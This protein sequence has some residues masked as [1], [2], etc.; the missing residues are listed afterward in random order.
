MR[1]WFDYKDVNYKTLNQLATKRLI[2]VNKILS[3]GRVIITDRLHASIMSV[4][5][6]KP[7]VIINEKFKKIYH[8]RESAFYGKLE[9]SPDYLRGRYAN[10]VEE[11]IDIAISLLND[12]T[13]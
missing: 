6:G 10:N 12:K 3:Q 9:C 4:L 2:L 1:D 8:T 13:L 11:A 7:H 5:M